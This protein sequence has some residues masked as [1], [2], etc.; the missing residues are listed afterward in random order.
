[1]IIKLKVTTTRPLT[2]N[3]GVRG[4]TKKDD[5]FKRMNI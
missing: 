4:K 2:F 5:G 3:V 1:M